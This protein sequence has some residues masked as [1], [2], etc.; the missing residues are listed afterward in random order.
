[1]ANATLSAPLTHRTLHESSFFSVLSIIR[2]NL[3]PVTIR[4]VTG[5]TTRAALIPAST[6]VRSAT[7][8]I[9][10]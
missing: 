8:T 2:Y 5:S 9:T 6:I 4:T 3:H 10:T 7:G 1:M